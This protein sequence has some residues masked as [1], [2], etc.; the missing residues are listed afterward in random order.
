MS[1]ESIP[2]QEEILVLSREAAFVNHEVTLAFI[3]FVEIL[4]WI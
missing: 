2:N 1:E 4:L 3:A